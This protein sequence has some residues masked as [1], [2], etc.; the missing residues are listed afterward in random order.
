MDTCQSNLFLE[1]VGLLRCVITDKNCHC[2]ADLPQGGLEIPCKLTFESTKGSSLVPKIRRLV[3]VCPPIEL[4]L[5][6]KAPKQ[7]VKVAGT[8]ESVEKRQV[9]DDVIDIDR[10]I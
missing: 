5:V 6:K 4:N 1:F 7:S 9:E 8:S 2:S 3:S 10:S